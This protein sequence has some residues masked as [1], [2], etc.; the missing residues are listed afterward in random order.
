MTPAEAA[1]RVHGI[2]DPFGALEITSNAPSGQVPMD[3]P[4]VERLRAAG[5][6]RREP[7]Q[8]WTPVAE[9]GAAGIE[10]VNFGPGE[11]PFAHTRD[12]HVAAADLARGYTVIDD[13]AK[14]R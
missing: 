11:P 7:K 3:N 12:E 1:E 5:D 6:L 13:F 9:F 2:C 8:A 10:A 14:A 4:L